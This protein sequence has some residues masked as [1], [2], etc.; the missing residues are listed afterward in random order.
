[1]HFDAVGFVIL[2]SPLI[3]LSLLGFPVKYWQDTLETLTLFTITK[4]SLFGYDQD[5]IYPWVARVKWS[6]VWPIGLTPLSF[7]L[8]SSFVQYLNASEFPI[9]VCT[10]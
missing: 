4:F 7:G 1:M 10:C 5:H 8:F 6:V 2:Y 9:H 3:I